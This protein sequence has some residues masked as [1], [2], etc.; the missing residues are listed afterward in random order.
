MR[1]KHKFDDS[2][3]L[4]ARRYAGG[5][6]EPGF[7]KEWVRLGNFD[8][9]LD[10]SYLIAPVFNGNIRVEKGDWILHNRDGN[11]LFMTDSEFKLQHNEVMY[12]TD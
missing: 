5:E 4:E 8:F 3:E 2:L 10:G 6:F 1:V 11:F 9:G 12:G 7:P